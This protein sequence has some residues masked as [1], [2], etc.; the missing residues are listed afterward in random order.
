[1][2]FEPKIE[3]RSYISLV[4]NGLAEQKKIFFLFDFHSFVLAT[5]GKGFIFPAVRQF[6]RA[7]GVS[8]KKFK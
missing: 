3:M 2:H 1:M 5:R 4:M 7:R 6:G 8:N